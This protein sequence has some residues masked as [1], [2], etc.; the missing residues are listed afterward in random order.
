[1]VALVFSVVGLTPFTWY[2]GL[3]GGI[4]GVISK[5]RTPSTRTGTWAIWVGFVGFALWS[6]L[7]G[8][9]ILGNQG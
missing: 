6:V 5:R 8:L 1:M 3:V 4:L 7:V 9:A 2:L